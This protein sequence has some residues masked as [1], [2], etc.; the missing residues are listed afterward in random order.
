[1]SPEPFSF[2]AMGCTVLVG[3]GTAAQRV[4]VAELFAVRERLLSRFDP[5]SELSRVNCSPSTSLVVSP[6]FAAT[7]GDALRA[8]R[9]TDGLVDPTLEAALVAAGYDDDVD[10]LDPHAPAAALDAPRPGRGG[11]L[12]LDGRVLRRPAG[13]RLD[14]AGV[15]KSRAVDDALQLLDG[16][17]FVSA[18]GDLATRSTLCVALPDG[19]EVRLDGGGIATSGTTRRRWTRAGRAAH[20]LID[21]RTGRP[22][23]SRW[24]TVTVA[25]ASC[26]AADVAAKAAFLLDGDGPGWLDARGLPGLLRDARGETVETRAWRIALEKAA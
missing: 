15:A 6:L 17:A 4:A 25:A 5:C 10:R 19:G 14:L 26:L 22:S 11:A 21:P 20:H 7:V 2:R 3:G 1:V 8:F 9:A 23:R 16:Q 24:V 12:R 13:L 18:G